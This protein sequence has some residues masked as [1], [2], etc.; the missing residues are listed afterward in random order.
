M[1]IM[2]LQIFL[3]MI[4]GFLLLLVALAAMASNMVVLVLKFSM[5][6]LVNLVFK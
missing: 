4:Y 1:N 6:L 5:H 3:T 2:F